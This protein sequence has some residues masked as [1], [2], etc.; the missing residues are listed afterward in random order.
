MTGAVELVAF[1]ARAPNR[2][3]ALSALADG[4]ATRAEVQE[5]TGVPR[6]TLSRILADFRDRDLVSRS[7][8]EFRLTPLGEVAAAELASL[9]EAVGAVQQLA[10]VREWLDLADVGFPVGRLAGADVVIPTDSDPLA[11]VRR[12][13]ALLADASRVRAVANSA[14]PGCIEAVWRAVT[15]GRQTLEW[16]TTPAALEVIAADPELAR[17]TR[18]LLESPAA[19]AYVSEAGFPQ[20]LFVVDD[21]V[22]TP[23]KDAAGTVQGHVET[24]DPEVREWAHGAIDDY[25]AAAEPAVPELLTA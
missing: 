16:A 20:A 4:P 23:V 1:L 25:L 12:A 18:D 8:H 24:D 2:L 13:E 9:L 3:E 19:A 21:V 6:A 7:G 11:P 17:Q 22:F 15:A 5:R 10:A 14:I